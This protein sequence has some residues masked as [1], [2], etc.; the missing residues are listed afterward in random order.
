MYKIKTTLGILDI[1]ENLEIYSDYNTLTFT[2]EGCKKLKELYL[3]SNLSLS[4]CKQFIIVELDDPYYG[5]PQF[6]IIKDNPVPSI[7]N[8]LHFLEKLRREY[9]KTNAP[10][11]SGNFGKSCIINFT[12]YVINKLQNGVENV[13]EEPK[14]S[15]KEILHKIENLMDYTND[16]ETLRDSLLFDNKFP[17]E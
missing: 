4:K 3:Y 6:E 17:E 9:M 13:K 16:L 11:E 5:S 1:P 7:D 8:K 12:R 10:I 14:F 2:T 15:I